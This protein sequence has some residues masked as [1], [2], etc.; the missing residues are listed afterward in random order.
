MG[1]QI[2]VVDIVFVLL[3][4]ILAIRGA[5]KGFVSEIGSMAALILGFGGAIVFYKPLSSL[6]GRYIGQSMWNPLIAFLVLFLALY[7]VVKLLERLLQNI[8]ERLNLNRL[9]SVLGFFLGLAEAVLLIGVVLFALNWQPFFDPR[10]LLS[11]SIFARFLFPLLPSPERIF[12]VE[13][14]L[15]DV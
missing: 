10:S 12:G 15:R 11:E 14:I 2:A 6:I 8:V 7:L 13:S 4:L 9:D 1:V 5:I 3:V